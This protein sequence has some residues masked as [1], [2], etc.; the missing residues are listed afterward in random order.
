[1]LNERIVATGIF[2]SRASFLHEA[3]SDYARAVLRLRKYL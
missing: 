1:M 2:V 3:V